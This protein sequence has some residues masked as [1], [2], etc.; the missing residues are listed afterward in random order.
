M[1]VRFDDIQR[2][3]ICAVMD[4]V[5]ADG[6]RQLTLAEAQRVFEAAGIPYFPWREARDANEAVAAADALGFPVALKLSS[7]VTTH[8]SDVGGVRLGLQTPGDVRDAASGILE[9]ARG[10]DPAATLVVQR[11]A[12][13][14]TEVIMGSSRDPKFGPLMMFGLGGIFVEVLKDVAFRIHPL[15]DVDAR[16]MI[17]SIK[18]YALLAGARGRQPTDTETIETALLRLS[19]LL[20][21]FPEIVEFDI[22]PFFAAD[23]AENSGA[24]DARITL[25]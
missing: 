1:Y 23:T 22:N 2:E 9:H 15:D 17:R 18:G 10:T 8:K 7:A 16:D 3:T 12:R 20:S 6:R 24:A 13:G 19:Q 14:G 11:M 4:S 21:E 25:A 5:R